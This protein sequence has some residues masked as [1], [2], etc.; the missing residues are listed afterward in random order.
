MPLAV[1]AKKWTAVGS[2]AELIEND[3]IHITTII[4]I[5]VLCDYGYDRNKNLKLYKEILTQ[6]PQVIHAVHAFSMGSLRYPGSVG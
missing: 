1:Y 4:T 3:T 5:N 2:R 6:S